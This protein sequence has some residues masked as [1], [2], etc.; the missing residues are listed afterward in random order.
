[1]QVRIVPKELFIFD[2]C[3]INSYGWE[4]LDFAHFNDCLMVSSPFGFFFF[5]C[6]LRMFTAVLARC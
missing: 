5:L 1:M 2:V 6:S 3:N 4:F